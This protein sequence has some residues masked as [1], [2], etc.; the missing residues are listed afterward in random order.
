MTDQL[1]PAPAEVRQF[2]EEKFD[3]EELATFCFDYFPQVQ[4]DFTLGM[5][6][7]QKVRLLLNY[8][9]N[10]DLWPNLVAALQKTRPDQFEQVFASVARPAP[11][12]VETPRAAGVIR[13]KS[14]S[15]TP[16]KMRNLHTGWRRI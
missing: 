15:A 12:V 4:D 11:Q 9:R 3:D 10:R 16:I 14:S 5:T 13:I 2:L 1:S 8:C 7:G 6:K